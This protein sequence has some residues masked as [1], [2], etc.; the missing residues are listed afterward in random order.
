MMPMTAIKDFDFIAG[1][2]TLVNRRL[3]KILANNTEWDEFGG[4][5]KAQILL[6]GMYNVEEMDLSERG[7]VGLTFRVFN[8]ATEQWSIYWVNNRRGEVD[9][10]VHGGFS[11][12]VGLFYGD[13]TH[14][15]QSIRVRYTWSGITDT[16][17]RW[18]QAYSTDNEKTW[19]TN[20]IVDLRR[21]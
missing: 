14:E 21:A 3:K 9:P 5:L 12:G 8:L 18:E 7:F 19:E 13:D 4:T 11:D 15:G 6:G 16:E 10:P 17:A 20:W 2:W 1:E